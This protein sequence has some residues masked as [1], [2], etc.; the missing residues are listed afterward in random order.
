MTLTQ[1]V[2]QDAR[3]VA[4]DFIDAFN[5]RDLE[6][7]QELVAPDV[8][9]RTSSGEALRGDDGLRALL[10]AAQEFD[11]LLVPYRGPEVEEADGGV[12][13]R[14]AVHE[15]VDPHRDE[16]ERVAEFDVRDGRIA[17]FAVQPAG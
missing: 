12:R 2:A 3:T 13:V 6:A 4:R 8:Q 16:I 14:I 11:V 9:L 15:L 7:L 17:A 1:A 5:A 10:K